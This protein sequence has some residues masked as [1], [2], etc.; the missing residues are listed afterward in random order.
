MTQIGKTI[1][2][3]CTRTS[4]WTLVVFAATSWVSAQ[5]LIPAAPAAAGTPPQEETKPAAPREYQFTIDK[6]LG[7][8][9]V[10]NQGRTGTCWSFAT[11]SFVESELIR[12]GGPTLDLSEMFIVRN[13]YEQKARNYLMRQGKTNFGEG[14]L[15]H[16]YV[17]S[18]ERFGLV[19]EQVFPGNRAE[20][21]GGHDHSELEAAMGGM[22]KALAERGKLSPRWDEAV[23]AVLDVY[24]GRNPGEF[25]WE[26]KTWTPLTFRDHLGVRAEDYVNLTSFSHHPFGKE[27]VLEIPDNFSAGS[28]LNL[29]LNDLTGVIDLAIEM[30]YTVAWDGDVSEPGFLS[31]QG[32]AVL[33]PG[34][35]N[36]PWRREPVPE[37]EVTQETRQA[38]FESL[39]TTDDHLMHLVGRAK[40]EDGRNYY[41]VKNS[42][43]P[44]GRHKGHVYLSEGYVRMK[45]MAIL[46]HRD[47]LEAWKKNQT[48]AAPAESTN[49]GSK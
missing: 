19:P 35:R 46:V 23:S 10:K 45:T 25:S 6:V 30:G 11:A 29:P 41:I 2:K 14:A 16:D 32:F 27:F 20:N 24:I 5:D 44:G 15:A 47:V 33:E 43:G 17:N 3:I 12:K 21:S 9:E 8:T 40:D 7:S 13:M 36:L 22:L 26:G 4:I 49:T 31:D 48:S 28:F 34:D 1:R 38:G 18:I 42:W 39:S 37:P